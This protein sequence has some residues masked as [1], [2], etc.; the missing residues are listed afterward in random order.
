MPSAWG[1][2]TPGRRQPVA[3]WGGYSKKQSKHEGPKVERMLF[4]G[5]DY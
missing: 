3:L 4:L 5:N 1:S 2:E